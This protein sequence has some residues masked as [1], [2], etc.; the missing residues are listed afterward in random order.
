MR[1]RH[2][3]LAALAERAG[4]DLVLVCGEQRAGGG[5]GWLT[6]W[7]VTAEAGAVFDPARASVLFIQHYNHV[8][9]ARRIAAQCEVRWGGTSTIAA[10]DA[11]LSRRS[12]KKIGLIG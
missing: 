1:R 11:E 5:V 3:L 12:S 4:V 8:P 2:G 10:L 9:L 7:P 6:G